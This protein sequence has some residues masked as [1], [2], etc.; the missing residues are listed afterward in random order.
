MKKRSYFSIQFLFLVLFFISY[1]QLTIAQAKVDA[2]EI[3]ERMVS[4]KDVSYKNVIIVGVLD[5]TNA[6]EQL[7]ELPPRKGYR[8][9]KVEISLKG[10]ISFVNCIFE[11]HV[12]AYF[13]D[14]GIGH[15]KGNSEYTFITNF[16]GEV[17]FKDCSFQKRAWFKYSAFDEDSDF[18]GTQFKGSSTFKYAVFPEKT[19]FFNAS[20]EEDN[21][22]KYAVFSEYVSFENAQFYEDAIFKYTK[23]KDGVSMNNTNFQDDLDFK[24]TKISGE[25]DN[26]NMVVDG[27]MNTKYFKVNGKGVEKI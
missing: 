22:F 9:N 7:K 2:A 6:V 12:Y 8:D 26:A 15:T 16:D 11:D 3:V 19:S 24:Y 18:S 27:Q 17:I 4:G 1:A 21:T 13:S 20:F 23:F 10:D 14:K 25:F 5:M